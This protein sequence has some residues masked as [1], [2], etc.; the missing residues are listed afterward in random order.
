MILFVADKFTKD[1]L[2][3]A[4]LSTDALMRTSKDT[5]MCVYS[6]N[7]TPDLIADH[8]DDYWVVTNFADMLDKVKQLL[9]DNVRYSIVEYDFKICRHR[10]PCWHA[11]MTGKPCDCVLNK[12]FFQYADIVF[13]MSKKQMDYYQARI[14]GIN[15][16][17]LSS[18]FHP[19]TLHNLK[20]LKQTEKK[21]YYIVTYS[22]SYV[23]GT[24]ESVKFCIE[25]GL[26]YRFVCNLSYDEM[27]KEFARAKGYVYMPAGMDTCPRAVIEAKLLGCNVLTNDNVL[28]KDEYWF[29]SSDDI[30]YQYLE[31]RTDYFWT[32]IHEQIENLVENATA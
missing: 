8:K 20:Q 6:N 28:H 13:F 17:V 23:K 19:E 22:H 4:E 30:I 11:Y 18:I 31:T 32:K 2:G 21:D 5:V 3:G 24:R 15:G 25:N 29:T 1:Y 14:T 12:E 27:L 26:D 10:S 16:V 9:V 7:V